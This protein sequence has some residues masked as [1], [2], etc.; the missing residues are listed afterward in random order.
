MLLTDIA[1]LGRVR[2]TSCVSCLLQPWFIYPEPLSYHLGPECLYY[3]KDSGYICIR[4]LLDLIASQTNSDGLC[5][6]PVCVHAFVSATS[7]LIESIHVFFFT[8]C[9]YKAGHVT[10]YGTSTFIFFCLLNLDFQPCG[11]GKLAQLP[12]LPRS[13]PCLGLGEPLS[14]P[15][16]YIS[17]YPTSIS[18][19]CKKRHCHHLPLIARG[20]IRSTHARWQIAPSLM[21]S[22]H[23]PLPLL[24]F[25]TVDNAHKKELSRIDVVI[26]SVS[27][28]LVGFLVWPGGLRSHLLSS[29]AHVYGSRAGHPTTRV[30]PL[31]PNPTA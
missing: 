30:R 13:P 2:V 25:S 16:L 4:P 8:T 10:V 31:T 24:G 9:S 15:W 3:S 29:L 22:G 5:F 18:D 1:L 28:F 11:D 7:E 6:P 26:Q 23:V 20:A 27:G 21:D 12:S 17:F 19:T 14:L